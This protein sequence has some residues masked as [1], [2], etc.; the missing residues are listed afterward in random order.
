MK[1]S[2]LIR[3]LAVLVSVCLLLSAAPP[4]AVRAA[5]A[6]ELQIGDYIALGT[7]RD[8]NMSF[9]LVWQMIHREGDRALLYGAQTVTQGEYDAS[10]HTMQASGLTVRHYGSS[11][12]RT[13]DA[14]TYLN[15]DD[16]TVR[17]DTDAMFNYDRYGRGLGVNYSLA[18]EALP[19]YEDMPGFLRFFELAERCLIQPTLHRVIHAETDNEYSSTNYTADQYG[20]D[21]SGASAIYDGQEASY[22]SD[23]V[24]LLNA[25]EYAD[26]VLG[27][28]LQQDYYNP[29]RDN[30]VES[31]PTW[32]SDS[33]KLDGGGIWLYTGVAQLIIDKRG[34]ATYGHTGNIG[35]FPSVETMPILRQACW[36]DLGYVNGFSGSGTYEDPYVLDI[37]QSVLEQ[38]ESRSLYENHPDKWDITVYRNDPKSNDYILGL[39][40]G[41]AYRAAKNAKITVEGMDYYTDDDGRAVVP[42]SYGGASIHLEGY[43]DRTLTCVQMSNNLSVYLEPAD[44]FPKPL[45]VWADGIDVL[46]NTLELELADEKTTSLEAEIYWAGQEPGTATLFQKS[47]RIDL[48]D[49]RITIHWPGSATVD[50]DPASP[51]HVQLTLQN[52][53]TMGSAKLGFHVQTVTPDQL[54]W[55]KNFSLRL[56]GKDTSFTLGKDAGILKDV[57]LNFALNLPVTASFE[58]EDGKFYAMA[59]I[60]PQFTSD[61]L[62]GK[63]SLKNIMKSTESLC[64]K[65]VDASKVFHEMEKKGQKIGQTDG[66]WG[67]GGGFKALLYWEGYTTV[68]GDGYIVTD[69]GAI[70]GANVSAKPPSLPLV[71]GGLPGYADAKFAGE[72]SGKGS[73]SMSD[74]IK[75]VMPNM[76]LDNKLSITVTGNVGIEDV[77][78][79]GVGAEGSLNFHNEFL[80]NTNVYSRVWL[81][82]QPFIQ[83]QVGWIGGQ[84]DLDLGPLNI[85]ATIYE[86]DADRGP[87]VRLPDLT[88][89]RAGLHRAQAAALSATGDLTSFG[90]AGTGAD[91]QVVAG[92]DGTLL[93]CYLAGGSNPC[94]QRL[95]AR[96]YDGETWSDPI[97]VED[98]GTPDLLPC[99]YL[100]DQTLYAAW[101]DF[102]RDCKGLDLD[103]MAPYSRIHAA[104]FDAAT[105]TF[106]PCAITEADGSLQ[107]RPKAGALD[108]KLI[109]TWQ[110]N[111]QADWQGVQGENSLYTADWSED[112]TFAPVCV[113]KTQYPIRS[114]LIIGDTVFW[115]ADLD[116]DLTTTADTEIFANE[117]RLTQNEVADLELQKANGWAYWQQDGAMALRNYNAE[118]PEIELDGLPLSHRYQIFSNGNGLRILLWPEP[119]ED[120]GETLMARWCVNDVWQDTPIAL[121]QGGGSILDYS[122]DM[123]QNGQLCVW[124][125]CAPEGGAPTLYAL[126]TKARSDLSL[127]EV[128]YN[129]ETYMDDA[130]LEIQ[131][132]VTNRGT[133]QTER[134]MLE[135]L[136]QDGTVVLTQHLGAMLQPGES[137]TF[138][139]SLPVETAVRSRK[140]QVR[141]TDLGRT[142]ENADNNELPLTLNW[143]DL[144]L[145][146]IRWTLREDGDAAI[147]ADVVS[148]GYGE[149]TQI[150]VSLRKDSPQGEAVQTQ[151]I[152]GLDTLELAPVRF[153][154]PFEEDACW[155]VTIDQDHEDDRMGNDK[156]FVVLQTTPGWTYENAE[157]DYDCHGDEAVCPSAK[158]TDAP[159][160]GVWSHTPIDWAVTTGI[161][162]GTS[163]TTFSPA[164]GCTRAQVVTFLWRAAGKPEPGTSQNPFRDVKQSDYFYNAV[165]WAVEQGITV[166]TDPDKF[167][168]GETCT[169][170]QIVTFLYRYEGKPEVKPAESFSDVK[171]SD[172]FAAPVT[173]AVEHGI[174]QGTGNGKFSPNDTCTREQVVTFLY[175]DI[176]E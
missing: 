41:D 34:R 145:E 144:A 30:A 42:F 56:L 160:Y 165:L 131:A 76:V 176:A 40:M 73:L 87:V 151:T 92:P 77:C 163:E 161:T 170:A 33:V 130:D 22:I 100:V 7:Y 52:G 74:A 152:Q 136:E 104:S 53:Q 71:I 2:T 86:Y 47:R 138:Y 10:D 70:L 119:A 107:S 162:A 174:T 8:E 121:T 63:A 123:D 157:A 156:D 85:N 68:D 79:V 108:N 65:S 4:P 135:L 11:S 49:N 67:F 27:Q 12:W 173:W 168:P 61:S 72:V 88:N 99:L 50:F 26:Y 37:D 113:T 14:R 28:N 1:H 154:V 128:W 35:V 134:I 148:R 21:L 124:L 81:K 9:P 43:C 172:Y 82:T 159:A 146:N 57:E 29:F 32:L 16:R 115:C 25:K 117:T 153:A 45:A 132:D 133:V 110:V 39:G 13:S 126:Q 75:D 60:S 103:Q 114:K 44:V 150:T 5:G 98:N 149:K 55:M 91:P 137:K 175:R 15:S 143:E 69:Q 24:F 102:D 83:G 155:Y 19:W 120:G 112:L 89:L 164:D 93:A 64:Q 6:D 118:E 106:T 17:Y 95:Y 97:A 90:A 105:K 171:T 166:G 36:I 111:D 140:L 122:A 38:A 58:V 54:E 51:V 48:K 101:T 116:K 142:D 127:D 96:Y 147:L 109:L 23:E 62:H 169:R 125:L 3:L 167:S 18:T 139:L 129:G 20:S 158:F 66:T 78:S 46:H 31:W 141:V 84:A 59:G 94:D 80:R